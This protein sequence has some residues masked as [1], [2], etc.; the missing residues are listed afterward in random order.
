MDTSLT[1]WIM[2]GLVVYVVCEHIGNHGYD[3]KT[4]SLEWLELYRGFHH[5]FSDHLADLNASACTAN[6]V[7]QSSAV[8]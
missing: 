7:M 5:Y 4:C 2:L 1:I 8:H 3:G 6:L